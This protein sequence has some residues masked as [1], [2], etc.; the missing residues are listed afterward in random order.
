MST[1]SREKFR[2]C[3]V[4]AMVGDAIGAVV[5]AESSEYIRSAYPT[6]DRILATKQVE[7]LFCGK[8]QAGRFTDD[9]QMMLAVAEW[10]VEDPEGSGKRLLE[11]F[12]KRHESWRRYGPGTEAVLRAFQEYPESWNTL[13]TMMFPH[14][15][16]GNGG[17]MRVAP[18][19]LACHSDLKTLTTRAVASSRPTH[20]NPLGC[21]GAVLQATAVALAVRATSFSPDAFLP[22]FRIALRHFASLMQDTAPY[23]KALESICEGLEKGMDCLSISE[24]LGTGVA[25]YESVPMAL[26]CFLRHGES[27]EEAVHQAILIGGDTDTIASMTGAISGAYLGMEAIP[28]SWIDYIREDEWT[29]E[30][31]QALADRLYDRYGKEGAEK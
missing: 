12:A 26:Y 22:P 13:S 6:V 27:F 2:G 15:S 25:A 28:Q 21:Q 14:G 19:G 4:G 9:T 8:W 31:V 7:E 30:A 10:L 23:D 24:K 1:S 11:F 16:Y 5:E 29:P 3:L 18:V 17:A 20:S